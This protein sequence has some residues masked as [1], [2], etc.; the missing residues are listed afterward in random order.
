M[1]SSLQIVENI[2]SDGTWQITASLLPGGT[3]P[4]DI[5]TWTNTGT[6]ELGQYQGVCNLQEYQRFQTFSGTPVTPVFGNRF[7]KYTKGVISN[8]PS[9]KLTQVKNC[10]IA[11]VQALSS[12]FETAGTNTTITNIT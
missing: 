6:S 7:V 1:S 9:S 3:L 8:I 12:A 5:F 11:E 10:I 2:G 4:R